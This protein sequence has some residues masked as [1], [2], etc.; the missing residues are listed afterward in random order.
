MRVNASMIA[1]VAL[2]V[3]ASFTLASCK[4]DGDRQE[5]PSPSTR[6][7]IRTYTKTLSTAPDKARDAAE[8]AE[9]RD[10]AQEEALKGL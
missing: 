6:E 9:K 2:A 4:G 10:N 1:F 7:V 3:A 8:A 5:A